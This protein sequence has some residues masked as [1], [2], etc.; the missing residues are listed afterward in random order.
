MILCTLAATPEA[1]SYITQQSTATRTAS[2]PVANQ[3]VAD[4]NQKTWWMGDGSTLGGLQFTAP[5][6]RNNGWWVISNR[7][8]HPNLIKAVTNNNQSTRVEL[9]PTFNVQAVMVGYDNSY[10]T[11]QGN[12]AFTTGEAPFPNPFQFGAL[13]EPKGAALSATG[14]SVNEAVGDIKKDFLFNGNKLT[15]ISGGS[16]MLSDPL[17]WPLLANTRNYI[18]STPNIINTTIPTAPVL[19]ANASGGALAVGTYAV[20]YTVEYPGGV[21][22]ASVAS[23]VTVVANGTITITAPGASNFPG[24]EGYKA[25][26]SL[27]G[28]TTPL[29]AT[30][31]GKYGLDQNMIV[32]QSWN[33]NGNG[34]LLGSLERIIPA[35]APSFNGGAFTVGGTGPGGFNIGEYVTNGINTG[36]QGLIGSPNTSSGGWGPIVTLG[37]D[38]FGYHQSG[39]VE[40]DSISAGV[41]DYGTFSGIGGGYLQRAMINQPSRLYVPSNT[42]YVP[43]IMLGTGGETAQAFAQFSGNKRTSIAGYATHVFWQYGTNDVASG[44]SAAALIGYT[45]T[46]AQQP[47]NGG[48][49]FIV[50]TL[51][52]RTGSPATDGWT[53]VTGQTYPWPTSDNA[54]E[55]N[56]RQYNNWVRSTGS[57]Q[58]ISNEALFGVYGANLVY[59]TNN[60][61]GG[62]G[63]ATTFLTAYPFVQGTQTVQVNGVTK[64]L[65]TD[66]SY[67]GAATINGTSYASGFVFTTAPPNTQTVTASYTSMAGLPTVLGTNATLPNQIGF[68]DGASKVEV[69]TAGAL[70]LNGGFWMPQTGA[71]LV[72]S[73]ST[74]GNTSSALNDTTQTWTQDQYKGYMCRILTDSTTPAAAGQ[75]SG[76]LSNTTTQLSVVWTTIPSSAATY[77]IYDP[78]TLDGIHPAY[79]G[80]AA[81]MTAVPV[82]SNGTITVTP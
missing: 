10:I 48:Q 21:R 6:S 36:Q 70:T 43:N 2:A 20:G 52:P 58:T 39:A 72:S 60:Y 26:I 27:V 47:I 65:T 81:A 1:Q 63:T 46:A 22:V 30:R 67:Y 69:N 40:G 19:T 5:P 24:A 56:R 45:Y 14:A 25:W 53:T 38:P 11:A 62:N 80:H 75:S 33:A 15:T 73:T 13:L 8:T 82:N 31:Q 35:V 17:K 71:P 32:D 3:L 77:K 55:G 54:S 44:T 41:G 37:Y 42:P 18:V 59:N 23:T 4:T 76:I 51:L 12:P 68:F 79:Q 66:Y 61:A 49:Y 29:Y 78:E 64:A 50:G 74:G 34:P 28:G 7:P 57:Q 16:F 9:V